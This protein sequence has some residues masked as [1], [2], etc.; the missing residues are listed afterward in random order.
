MYTAIQTWVNARAT[1]V[2]A[3][4]ADTANK[5][6]EIETGF[7][8]K[9]NANSESDKHYQT[10]IDG[11]ET[12]PGESTKIDYVNVVVEFAF[13]IANNRDNYG[14]MIT[15]YLKAFQREINRMGNA[16]VTS[17][18]YTVYGVPDES[19]LP[20][21]EGTNDFEDG[22]IYPTIS[23]TLRVGDANA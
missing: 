9:E 23:F 13:L 19:S 22:H 15:T 16:T 18:N 14:T 21:I 8:T 17:A 11:W 1:A 3:L 2:S 6:T 10:K 20:V 7:V 5:L 12:A 4:I